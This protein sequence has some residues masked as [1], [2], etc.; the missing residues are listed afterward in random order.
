[1]EQPLASFRFNGRLFVTAKALSGKG[2]WRGP[3]DFVRLER[4]PN[5][6]IL[7]LA[8]RL[9]TGIVVLRFRDNAV[10]L[11]M[12]DLRFRQTWTGTLAFDGVHVDGE[13]RSSPDG[14][15]AKVTGTLV[16]PVPSGNWLLS[17]DWLEKGV[18]YAFS[19]VLVAE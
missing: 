11:T 3:G 15:L 7:E 16:E 18:L 14:C 4:E 5:F 10:G 9:N 17:A 8:P 2:E 1:L 13:L 12:R 19:A 6:A